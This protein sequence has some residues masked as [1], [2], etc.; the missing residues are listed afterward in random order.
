MG[1]FKF[2]NCGPV[3]DHALDAL[4]PDDEAARRAEFVAAVAL[5]LTPGVG[6][7]TIVRLLETFGTLDAILHADSKALRTVNGI[8]AKIA[9]AIR[10]NDTEYL[11]RLD[12]DLKDWAAPKGINRV[13]AATW[14][15]VGYPPPLAD[16]SDGPLV[17]FYRG[18]WLESDWQAVAIVGTR[19]ASTRALR[20]AS[21]MAA[22]FATEAW[23]VVSGLARGIDT[24][25]L[26]GAVEAG[27]R[28]LAVLGS[29]IRPEVIYPPENRTLADR[30][31]AKGALLCEGH[32]MAQPSAQGL[33]I[34]NRLISG[35]SRAVIVVEGGAT[36]G[37]MHA[38]RFALNQGRLLFTFPDGGS[39]CAQLLDNGA[40]PFESIEQVI[41]AITSRR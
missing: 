31:A 12:A 21:D 4:R 40:Q 23:T 5:G 27:G 35:L 32:P 11:Q 9:A 13:K 36:S 14:D 24:A 10:Q 25:A 6:A 18:A 39:G 16:L 26:S 22:A 7:K 28:A 30:I 41:A 15:S 29:G 1:R 17:T 19:E 37:A 2:Q 33:T 3:T 38:A 20:R 8:G 34:R